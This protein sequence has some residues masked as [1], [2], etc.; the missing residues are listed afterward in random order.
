MATLI[1]RQVLGQDA[2]RATNEDNSERQVDVKSALRFYEN[3]VVYVAI[4]LSGFRAQVGNTSGAFSQQFNSE[5]LEPT[6]ETYY[7]RMRLTLT[8]V[9]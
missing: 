8:P 5:I 6:T 2:S 9:L 4:R 7:L 1:A 3:D